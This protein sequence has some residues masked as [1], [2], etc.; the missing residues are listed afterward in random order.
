MKKLIKA[1]EEYGISSLLSNAVSEE[2]VDTGR[3]N[4]LVSTVIEVDGDYYM[5]EWLKAR[6]EMGM[7]ELPTSAEDFTKVYREESV[8]VKAEVNY[9]ESND[10]KSHFKTLLPIIDNNALKESISLDE[11]NV[12]SE[13]LVEVKSLLKDVYKLGDLIGL[14]DYPIAINNYLSNIEELL[15]HIKGELK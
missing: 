11:A 1:I 10:A 14:N 15:S 8:V 9:K 2:V 6:T 3:W 4:D 7:D 13:K 12:M 5:T